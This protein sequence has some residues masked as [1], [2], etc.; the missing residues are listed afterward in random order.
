VNLHRISKEKFRTRVQILNRS[1]FERS[2]VD[3]VLIDEINYLS[4]SENT[5][6]ISSL[7]DVAV[8]IIS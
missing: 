5:V 6:N 3:V 7:I 8:E 4:R 1:F 2:K